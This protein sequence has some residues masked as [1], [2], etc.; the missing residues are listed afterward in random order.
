[1]SSLGVIVTLVLKRQGKGRE[2]TQSHKTLYFS[3]LWGRHPW[4]DSHKI[5]HA[6]C[7]KQHNQYVQFL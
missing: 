5:W 1:M 3:Y 6:C 7:P 4:A 2:G